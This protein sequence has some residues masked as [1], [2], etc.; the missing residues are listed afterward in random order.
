MDGRPAAGRRLRLAGRPTCCCAGAPSWASAPCWSSRI[1]ARGPAG[2][3]DVAV[4]GFAELDDELAGGTADV[5]VTDHHRDELGELLRDALARPARWVGVMG[6]PRHE[7]PHVAALTALGR[8]AGGDRPGAPADRPRHR[9]AGAGG[10]RRVDAGRAARRPQRPQRRLRPRRLSGRARRRP[11]RRRPRHQRAEAGRAGPRRRGSWRRPSGATRSTA[12]HPAAP[13]P[14]CAPG[15]TAFDEALAAVAPALA[16]APGAGAGPR[17][18]RCTAPSSSTTPGRRC[19]RRCCGPTPGPPRSSTCWRALPE[20]DRAA[21]ANPLVAGHDRPDAGLAGPARAGGRCAQAAAVLLPKDALR[22]TL[23]PRPAA[24][25]R[26]Q[27]RLGDAAL[28]RHHRRLVAGG[29]RRRRRRPGAAAGRAPVGRGRRDGDAAGR[30]G[31]GRDRRRGHPAGAARRRHARSRRSTSGTGAQLL[32]P[33]LG[34]AAGRR[35][36]RARLR[37]RRRAAGTRWRRCRTAARRGSGCAACSGCRWAEL[38]DAAAATP[39]GAGG[40]AVPAV[41]RPASAAG[42]ARP[43]GPRR[44]ERPAPGHDPRGPGARGGRGGRLRDRGGVRA[45]STCRTGDEPVVLTGGGARSPR[46]PAAAR[47]R[48]AAGRCGTSR[49]AAPRRSVRRCWPAAASA[50]D[51]VPEGPP[52]PWSSR[53][54]TTGSAPPRTAGPGPSSGRRRAPPRPARARASRAASC[55]TPLVASALPPP[56]PGAPERS[57]NRPPASRTITSSA[58]RSQTDTSGS[59]AMSTAPSASRQ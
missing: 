43:V 16:G 38:F 26:P 31:A 58:A 40:V 10:D 13:R 1:P 46:R 28:G 19:G 2:T 24:G 50:L 27:R 52:A 8:A 49:C 41:P 57:V 7:G 23:L 29:G 56:G 32:R 36:G 21:L 4:R 25:H 37:R 9:L 3:P 14:T 53:G 20:A 54:P 11:A 44:L 34:A 39:A 15:G 5:V 51:V 17:R 22:A 35:P 55:R 42:V 6:N 12:R 47:R 59:Q 33:G 30:R 48:A 45:C 18:G